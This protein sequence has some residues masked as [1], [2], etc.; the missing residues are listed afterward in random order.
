MHDPDA[1]AFEIPRPWPERRRLA[2]HRYWPAMVTVWHREPRGHD[3]GEVCLH[4]RR[5]GETVTV[6]NGW[7]WHVHHW[8]VQF[9]AL[10]KMRRRLLTR[11]AWCGG[12]S[13]KADPVNNGYPSGR[14]GRWWQGEPSLWHSDCITISE[15]H[16][17]C[18][19]AIPDPQH[20]DYGRCR[21]CTRS[22]SYRE[23]LAK[24]DRMRVLAEVPCGKRDPDAYRR[25]IEMVA[26]EREV[27]GG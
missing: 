1:V 25:I 14:E 27:S 22:R 24:L 20:G 11:C 12:R 3:S 18:L 23:T 17:T 13:T 19:C 26:A 21:Y 10:R 8:R 5:D 16:H 6:L 15:A 9:P 7:R 4:Y 2:G